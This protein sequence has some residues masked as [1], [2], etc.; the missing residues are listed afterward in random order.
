MRLRPGDLTT[1]Y[2]KRRIVT[3]D[4]HDNDVVTFAEGIIE[5]EMNIQAAGG[6]VNA[7]TYGERLA[8]MKSCKY[9]GDLIREG[10][11]EGDGIC[12]YKEIRDRPAH[13]DNVRAGM[14]QLPGI[15]PF[16]F[17][18]NYK[19]VSIHNYSTHQNIMIERIGGVDGSTD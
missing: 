10:R 18:P 1:V 2:L 4:K 5:L 9:Q 7:Q 15:K 3:Q 12:L 6:A 19:I 8:Y 13:L 16:E 11:N 14:A 17:E